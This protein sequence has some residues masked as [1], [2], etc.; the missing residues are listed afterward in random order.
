MRRMETSLNISCFS[1]RLNR[2]QVQE[3]EQGGEH[4]TTVSAFPIGKIR[5]KK[6]KKHPSWWGSEHEISGAYL[7]DIR[8]QAS[9]HIPVIK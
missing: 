9:C 6:K 7:K 5:K 4:L 3:A 1:Q 8:E 2:C